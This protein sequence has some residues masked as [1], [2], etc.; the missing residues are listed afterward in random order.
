MKTIITA[1]KFNARKLSYIPY[2]WYQLYILHWAI[3][4]LSPDS[5]TWQQRTL[6]SIL[7]SADK[8]NIFKRRIWCTYT[9]CNILTFSV[10][11]GSALASSN[12]ST[13]FKCPFCVARMSEVSPWVPPGY[14]IIYQHSCILQHADCVQPLKLWSIPYIP[15]PGRW[16]ELQLSGVLLLPPTAPSM[17]PASTEF[18]HPVYNIILSSSTVLTTIS[19]KTVVLTKNDLVLNL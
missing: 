8:N 6:H 14:N 11:L 19:F 13:T 18:Y 3:V 1:A 4:E 12:A 16:L 17:K 15:D 2:P 5:Q 7:L 10:M 9:V